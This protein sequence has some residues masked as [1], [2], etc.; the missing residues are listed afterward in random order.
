MSPNCKQSD[1]LTKCQDDNVQK[2]FKIKEKTFPPQ[3]FQKSRYIGVDGKVWSNQWYMKMVWQ[4]KKSIQCINLHDPGAEKK[5]ISIVWQQRQK[6]TNMQ[7]CPY[8]QETK[9]KE[10]LCS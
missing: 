10:S 6:M 2:D 4:L 8:K 3:N 7:L 1:Q 5:T 9:Q